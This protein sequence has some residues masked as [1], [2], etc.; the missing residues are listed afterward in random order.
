MLIKK[1]KS[2]YFFTV[3]HLLASLLFCFILVLIKLFKKPIYKSKVKNVIFIYSKKHFNPENTKSVHF[4]Y[5][6]SYQIANDFYDFFK[7]EGFKIAYF[8][9][10]ENIP[11]NLSCDLLVGLSCPAFNRASWLYKSSTKFLIA[12]N[13]HPIYRN[14]QILREALSLKVKMTDECI[15]PFTQILSIFYADKILLT[16]N[17]HV[18]NTF[19]YFFSK[20]RD[21][22]LIAGSINTEKFFPNYS[23]RSNTV[24]RVIYPTSYL[25]L[26]KG[27]LRFLEAWSRLFPELHDNIE[28]ILF[29]EMCSSTKDM[30]DDYCQRFRNIK[31]LGW[32]NDKDLVAELQASHIVAS[33]SMEEG[34]AYSLLEAIS[35]GCTPVVTS[36]CGLN[37]DLKYEILNARDSKSVATILAKAILEEKTSSH[38]HHHRMQLQTS[39]KKVIEKKLY[40]LLRLP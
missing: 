1:I 6:G 35:C 25:G 28:L 2:S 15:N 37:I 12:V 40:E 7:N 17:A 34:Q 36:N 20:P 29:G 16:G 31:N 18:K 14:M 32:L 3:A 8:D 9:M 13:S 4:P 10:H 22:E 11:T 33:L 39:N 30:I 24:I 21:I 23:S 26:R 38:D 27:V 19:L 5:S